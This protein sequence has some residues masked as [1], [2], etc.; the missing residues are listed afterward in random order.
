M[1]FQGFY[2]TRG[3]ALAAKIAAGT[4]LT[5]TKVTAGSGETAKTAATLAQEQ[6]TLT[7][8]TA[9]GV[10]QSFAPL[11]IGSDDADTDQRV[12]DFCGAYQASLTED[13]KKRLPE[14][15]PTLTAPL[16]Q[17]PKRGIQRIR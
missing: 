12:R 5:I 13:I 15:P 10:P 17:R 4:K 2:T 3:L 7:A 14:Q 11:L 1:S 6:Q 9:A 8:G 16:P